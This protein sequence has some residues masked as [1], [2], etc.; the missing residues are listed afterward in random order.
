MF[1]YVLWASQVAL[2]V[3]KSPANAGHIRDTG[4][5]P[6][7]GR[8]SGEGNGNPL[9]YFCLKN[10]M[11][12][13]AWWT[14]VYGVAEL[15][16]TEHSRAGTQ[17]MTC[18]EVV[19][20]SLQTHGLYIPPGSSVH[21]VLQAKIL[22]WVTISFSRGSSQIRDQTHFSYIGRQILTTEPPGKPL[23]YLGY[24][25]FVEMISQ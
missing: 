11:D 2:V 3:K 25:L 14:A 24:V 6:G 23:F 10:S 16:M 8:S 22:E 7:L 15:D 19:S 17:P 4:S 1:F 21:G 13:G 5:I 12:R 20:D 18:S 9:Q